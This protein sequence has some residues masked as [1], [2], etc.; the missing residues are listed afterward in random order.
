MNQEDYDK[1]AKLVVDR[2]SECRTQELVFTARVMPDMPTDFWVKVVARSVKKGETMGK[3]LHRFRT[4]SGKELVEILN[5]PFAMQMID[6]LSWI[7]MEDLRR[8][9]GRNRLPIL[10]LHTLLSLIE[11]NLLEYRQGP[12]GEP[13]FRLPAE[14]IKTTKTTVETSTVPKHS[15]N[16]DKEKAKK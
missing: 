13:E 11:R 15:P 7:S 3:A 5:V 4:A 12:T 8:Y 6:D 1:I 16:A 2:L 10:E 9:A 14:L